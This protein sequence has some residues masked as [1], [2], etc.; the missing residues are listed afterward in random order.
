[1]DTPSHSHAFNLSSV[2]ISKVRY[3][4]APLNEKHTVYNAKN[5]DFWYL[6]TEDWPGNVITREVAGYL[7]SIL[8]EG[9]HS[10]A[11]ICL[12]PSCWKIIF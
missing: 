11:R 5:S 8:Y 7:H 1:M 4:L 6:I 3:F 9:D 12:H 10:C 2:F